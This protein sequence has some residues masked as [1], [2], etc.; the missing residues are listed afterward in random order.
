MCNVRPEK[1]DPNRVQVTVL[2]NIINHPRDKNTPTADLLTL[3]ILLNIVISTLDAIC[4]TI[5]YLDTPLDR[6]EYTKMKLANF[7]K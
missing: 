4:V 7:V 3:K 1:D 6:Y 5:N 2:R